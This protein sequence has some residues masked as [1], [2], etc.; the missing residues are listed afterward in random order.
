MLVTVAATRPQTG[1]RTETPDAAA[2]QQIRQEALQRSQ[3]KTI[4][5]TLTDVY[6]PR[7]TG[8]PNL[9]A[10]GDYVIEQLKG[11]GIADAR[12]ELWG[13][14]GPG[15]ANERFVALA[16]SPLS[17]PLIAYPKAWTP[18]TTGDVRGEAVV[19]RVDHDADFEKYRGKLRGKFVLTLPVRPDDTAFARRRMEFF[20]NEAVLALLEP[21]SGRSG[22]VLVGD[23]RVATSFAAGMYPWPEPVPPQVVLASEHYNWIARTIERGVPVALEMNIASTYFTM[24][25]NSFN[26]IAEI[27][28]SEQPDQVVMIG[29]HLDSMHVGTGAI[30]N[31]GGC[32]VV[33]EAMRILQ[34]RRFRMR[35]TVRL[36]LWTGSEQGGQGSRGYI[37]QHFVDENTRQLRPAH[38]TLSA[39]FD[40]DD[41]TGPFQ[42]IYVQGNEAV[43]PIFE[44]WMAPFSVTGMAKVSLESRAGKDHLSFDAAGL[45][46]FHFMQEGADRD[47]ELRQS[48]FDVYDRL[49]TDALEQNAAIVAAFAYSA[50]NRAEPLPR[51]AASR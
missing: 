42:G 14:F 45:N 4:A 27:R 20:V 25:P 50:A 28:G 10:A 15:W 49:D 12:P 17:F 34:A 41:G 30:D 44:Q 51:K 31:A 24:E 40:V 6:G 46:G 43:A 47:D 22:A 9:R 23:G 26:V 48:N 36:A 21:G 16:V 32:A 18:G 3:V 37:A 19:A 39:Y 7:L 13:P 38:S 33:L 1:Q 5:G 29:A 35:R 8:S 2:I 11:W